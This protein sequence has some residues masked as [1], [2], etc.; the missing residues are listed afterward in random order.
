MPEEPCVVGVDYGT[1]SGRAVVVR[2]RDGAELAS[3]EHVYPHA[4][5][6]RELP[7]GTRQSRAF[8]VRPPATISSRTGRCGRQSPVTGAPGSADHAQHAAARPARSGRCPT[9]PAAGRLTGRCS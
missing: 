7:D 3:A 5:L 6:D 8:F 4:V 9:T 1:L 2:V